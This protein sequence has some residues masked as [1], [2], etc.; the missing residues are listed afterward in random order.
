MEQLASGSIWFKL[1][2]SPLFFQPSA[3]MRSVGYFVC[4]SVTALTATAFVS[5]CN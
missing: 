5:G 1:Y 2:V 3:R 4:A